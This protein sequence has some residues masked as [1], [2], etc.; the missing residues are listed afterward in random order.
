MQS[1]NERLDWLLA[2]VPRE[3]GRF[4][5]RFE[6]VDVE[7]ALND[8]VTADGG[9]RLGGGDWLRAVREDRVDVSDESCTPYLNALEN[10]LRLPRGYF[11]D[12]TL[13]G[14]TDQLIKMTAELP[15]TTVIGPCRS[16]PTAS[17]VDDLLRLT[18]LL[19][20]TYRSRESAKPS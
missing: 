7:T 6:I 2:V 16:T 9:Q 3:P 4:A 5:G 20:D 1:F 19:R 10:L 8:S 13:A 17:E 11:R 12:E 18:E 14:S 15:G